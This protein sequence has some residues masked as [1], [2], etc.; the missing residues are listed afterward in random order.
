MNAKQRE[1][2]EYSTASGATIT[3]Q[4]AAREQFAQVAPALIAPSLTNP[5]KN[6]DAAKLQE[7]ADSIRSTGVH[8][9]LLAR[10]L[11]E[12]RLDDTFRNRG[13]GEP[14]PT[15]ELVCG[16]RRLR[17]SKLAGV[18]TIPVLIRALADEQVLKIQ[19]IE[20]LQRDDLTALEE[21][22]GYQRL[23]DMEGSGVTVDSLAGEIG[24]SR[25]Y[26]FQRLQLLK[27]GAEAKKALGEGKIDVS[28]ATLL[29]RIPDPTLQI[30]ATKE[31]S[32]TDGLGD[33]TYSTRAAESWLK[34][35]V[36]LKLADA[37]F[38]TGD[39]TLCPAAGACTTCPK[40]TGANPD[41]FADVQGPDM[42]T[43]PD[44]F[45]TKGDAHVQRVVAEAKA[46]GMEVIEGKEALEI[47][48]YDHSYMRGY[49]DVDTETVGEG[50]QEK[51]LREHLTSKAQKSQIKVLVNPHT[52]QVR[53]VVP[54]AVADELEAKLMTPESKAQISK[55]RKE[56]DARAAKEA[57]FRQQMNFQAR[58]RGLAVE[59]IA[60]RIV[61]GDVRHFEPSLLLGILTAFTDN[62]GT[63][64]SEIYRALETLGAVE[65][66]ATI[67]LEDVM[68]NL[69]D[70]QLG[71]IIALALL[72]KDAH[73]DFDWVNETKVPLTEAPIIDSLAATLDI[74]LDALR[75]EV[76]A[77]I[78]A[79]QE[80]E[81]QQGTKAPK[82]KESKL[83]PA[84]AQAGI[85][86][87]L[88][89]EEREAD[90][91]QEDNDDEAGE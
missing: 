48:S 26:V 56:G 53:H 59:H 71:P 82:A 38:S 55:S 88:A 91:D 10:P 90:S 19:V 54:K 23:L 46:K 47:L 72:Y 28:K 83:S 3:D 87:A 30:K 24:K 58:W 74:D 77:Q 12:A 61:G 41:L 65:E 29:S 86:Q 27:L 2:K 52:N 14:L 80:P 36:M 51:P 22:E 15:Y 70:V 50:D 34:M 76:Q 18:A 42:C 81:K 6:F 49:C 67:A 43:D 63:M 5:R 32:R 21:A 9:P 25:R 62:Y 37:R 20:N 44:C 11:S 60:P 66:D 35:N 78:R 64:E 69:P 68:D 17:A 85:S 13:D 45:K 8:Q 73:A 75:A 40:R 79:E 1:P 16:E 7:L 57:L 84:E 39:A 89:D 4:A 31:L 33:P